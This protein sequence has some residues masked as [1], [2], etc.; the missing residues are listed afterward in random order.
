[1][2]IEWPIK[3]GLLSVTTFVVSVSGGCGV[4]T[5]PVETFASQGIS[6]GREGFVDATSSDLPQPLRDA[7]A[8]VAI[9]V[10]RDALSS[11]DELGCQLDV[12]RFQPPA[13]FDAPLCFSSW[14]TTTW[15]VDTDDACSAFR[16][17]DNSRVLMTADHCLAD[18]P[19]ENAVVIFDLYASRRREWAEERKTIYV[20]RANIFYCQEKPDKPYATQ[21]EDW[22][23]FVVDRATRRKPLIETDIPIQAGEAL[24]LIG[25]PFAV[26][27]LTSD[28]GRVRTIDS[29]GAPYIT[30]GNG[31]RWQFDSRGKVFYASIDAFPGHSGAPLVNETGAVRGMLIS[32]PSDYDTYEQQFEMHPRGSCLTTR[33]LTT[34]NQAI[35]TLQHESVEQG[36]RAVYPGALVLTDAMR[37][38]I[39]RQ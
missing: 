9:F 25:H 16:I 5:D 4:S 38:L 24:R 18:H 3:N 2:S 26:E 20:P 22:A 11:C 17:G 21:T 34:A 12:K 7:A 39:Q 35:A 6:Y 1:M 29:G 36:M 27:M 31:R 28:I 32:G 15:S 37:A 14:L 10:S 13:K 19:C 30:E 23:V 33:I 8:A